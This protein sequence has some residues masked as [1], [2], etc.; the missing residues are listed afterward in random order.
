[1]DSSEFKRLILPMSR[2]LFNF[3]HM[4][5]RDQ[6]E[7]Q[8]AV[9]EVC[10]KLWNLRDRLKE[11]HNP[12]AFAMKTM[13]NWCLDHMKSR[14]PVY[15]DQYHSGID[16]QT[17]QKNPLESL[18][19]TDMME[20][21]TRVLDRLP[22]QQRSIFQLRDLEGYEFDEIADIMDMTINTVRVN[23]SRARTRLREELHKIRVY[24]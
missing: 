17:G 23:L 7:A 15:V 21:F 16:R 14:K 12:E 6:A 2:K 11:I 4:M 5:L 8:D 9:Q 19:N 3:A 20:H 10:L 24:G 18:E 13:K 22:E 1:M